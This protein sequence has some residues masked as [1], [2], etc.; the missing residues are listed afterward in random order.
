MG[1]TT[2]GGRFSRSQGD[3]T[4][5]EHVNKLEQPR[6]VIHF[7]IFN[8]TLKLLYISIYM[9]IFCSYCVTLVYMNILECQKFIFLNIVTQRSSTEKNFWLRQAYLPSL[10]CLSTRYLWTYVYSEAPL[11][12]PPPRLLDAFCVPLSLPFVLFGLLLGYCSTFGVCCPS[13]ST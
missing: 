4:T 8:N 10:V 11:Y 9:Y 7:F 2:R 5:Q 13:P 12:F 3:T 6:K 1:I